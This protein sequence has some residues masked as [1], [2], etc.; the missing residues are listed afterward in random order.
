MKFKMNSRKLFYYY[1]GML[2]I[3][4]FEQ[5]CTKQS[6]PSAVASLNV[7]NALPTSSPL[8]LVQGSVAPFIGTFSGVGT[9]S[10][11]SS[12]VLTPARGSESVYALQ[13]NVDTASADSKAPAYM[14]NTPLSFTAGGLYSLFITGKD[15]TSPDF[16]FVQD[17]V[18]V[19]TDS[20]VGIRFADLSAG[21]GS[22]SVDIQGQP[23]G[24][25]V[26]SLAYKEVTSFKSYHATTS[27]SSYVFEFRDGVSGNLL[28]TY[29]LS[30]V[31][32]NNPNITNTVLFRNLTIALI[33]QPAGGT[34]PQSCIR[35]NSF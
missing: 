33:G 12:T 16:V 7:I 29:T 8:I 23:N 21:S 30:G 15:T 22:V 24:S 27:V 26:P 5:S 11:A 17:Q 2:F 34:V 20:T 28:A 14:L 6:S 4:L 3:A 9:L 31:N 18:S 25:E 1:C 32:T 35:V 19:R 13:K 10:Y